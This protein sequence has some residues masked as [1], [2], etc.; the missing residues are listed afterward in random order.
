MAPIWRRMT[1]HSIDTRQGLPTEMQILLRDYPRVTWP[2][3]PN[4]ARSTQNWMAAHSMFRQLAAIITQETQ[5]F[6]DKASD[7][8][9][10]AG[11]LAHYG[12]LLVR[13]LHGHHHWEDRAF[14][15]EL[16]AA[17]PRFAAGLA[18]LEGDHVAL[19]ALLERFTRQANRVVQLATLEEAQMPA[20]A[21][22]LAEVSAGIEQFLHRHL[23]DEE[24]LAVPI[25]LHHRLRG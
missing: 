4:L 6:L 20:E 3:N 18:M 24:E 12:N 17:D 14:F 2:E 16:E 7:P 15:P 11:R 5:G 19:D 25:L 13:N 9:R 22:P 23:T 10:Y 8:Q 21:G 1:Q